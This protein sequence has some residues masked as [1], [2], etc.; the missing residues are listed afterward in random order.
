MSISDYD[1]RHVGEIVHG[2]G[3]WFTADLL[4]ALDTLLPH[5]DETNRARLI[6]AFPEEVAAY[7]AWA[8]GDGDASRPEP[9]EGPWMERDG[10]LVQE[11]TS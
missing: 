11:E 8:R 7:E 2:Y 9:G 4:R 10:V 1:R 6:A 3:T 5:A